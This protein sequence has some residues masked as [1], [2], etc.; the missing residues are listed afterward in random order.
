MPR[1]K[2]S[3]APARLFDLHSA[4]NRQ[5]AVEL[6]GYDPT[7]AAALSAHRDRLAGYLG[8]T[9]AALV[10]VEPVGEPTA[11]ALERELARVEGEFCGRWLSTADDLARL[12]AEPADHLTWA[13][14]GV[15]GLGRLLSS[16]ADLAQLD[17]LFERGV[18]VFRPAA[19]DGSAGTLVEPADGTPSAL[20]AA[21]VAHLARVSQDPGRPVLDLA[22][23]PG[24]AVTAWLDRIDAAGGRV[25]P[26]VSRG[27]PLA[28]LSTGDRARIRA[29]G[30]V[31]AVSP[32]GPW[33][34]T[35]EAVQGALTE[36]IATAGTAEGLGLGPDWLGRAATLPGLE[37]ADALA[38]WLTGAFD[39]P[40]ARA[41]GS[42]SAW[43]LVRRALGVADA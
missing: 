1:P 16:A 36:A 32:G 22:D 21:L 35:A 6:V 2:P 34:A 12:G 23:L 20:G 5:Y 39:A 17:R 18:R 13:L 8:A 41:L 40:T 38:T 31:V 28:S 26:L 24:P 11:A 29:R 7:A 9:A 10:F 37:T 15:A 43:S 19:D 33:F 27:N 25:L 30:G 42:G 14:V 3:P 4:W